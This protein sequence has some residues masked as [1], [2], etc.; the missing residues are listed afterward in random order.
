METGP[1]L[2]HC[3]ALSKH[4]ILG[5]SRE[6]CTAQRWQISSLGLFLTCNVLLGP[7]SPSWARPKSID[8]G[9]K[10]GKIHDID[11]VVGWLFSKPEMYKEIIG[12]RMPMATIP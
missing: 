1:S 11:L 2:A 4:L 3:P 7:T 12:L 10:I 6:V 5:W 8:P 9:E